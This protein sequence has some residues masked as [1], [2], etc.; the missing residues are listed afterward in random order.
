MSLLE[1]KPIQT[2]FQKSHWNH[3]QL[4]RQGDVAV[5]ERWKEGGLKP[6]FEVIRVLHHPER[7]FAGKFFPAYE[8]YPGE[9][10]WGIHGWTYTDGEA[11]WKKAQELMNHEKEKMVRTPLG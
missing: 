7:T 1:E 10:Q 4:F 6:H 9:S 11:A 2:E 3:K 8:G 5:Y